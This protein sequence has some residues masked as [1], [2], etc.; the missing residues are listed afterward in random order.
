VK[1]LT[2][3]ALLWCGAAQAQNAKPA[4][5]PMRAFNPPATIE[6]TIAG[7]RTSLVPYG[8]TPTARVELVFR[9]GRGTELDGEA[10]L[11]QLVGDYLLEGTTARA[12]SAVA[13]ELARIGT[14][15]G[16]LTVSVGT[17]ETIVAAEVLAESAPRLVEIIGEVAL[18]PAFD[19]AALERLRGAVRRRNQ[20]ASAEAIAA[21]RVN[22]A[23]FP[24]YPAD[25]MPTDSGLARL[26]VEA[27]RRFHQ[28]EYVA[29]RA[30]LYV[31][32]VFDAAKVESAARS[33]LRAI[34]AGTP[35][36][37]FPAAS[38]R[39]AGGDSLPV[40]QIIDRPGA[41][42]TRIH[43]AYPVVDQTHPDHL[44]LN[45]LNS[46]MGSVQ[47][48]RIIANVR[49]RHGYSYN[50]STRL[51]RRPGATSWTIQGD[52]NRDVTGAA[53]REI[54]GEMRRAGT[55]PPSESELA[56]FQRFMAGGMIVEMATARG[57]LDY[58]RFLDL[59]GADRD[60][61]RTL[62]P[63]IHAVTPTDLLRVHSQYLRGDRAV[64]VLVGDAAAI[65]PQLA[66]WAQV[67]RQE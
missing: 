33:A 22:N 41:T 55:E 66:G 62:V 10:G 19:S 29:A 49:E 27:A 7:M 21:A 50:I 48:S 39:T 63:S 51:A 13:R 58:L 31:A 64:I 15:G 45:E 61:L 46:V 54:L 1:R 65:E 57:I 12:G 6:R 34:R 9:S 23:L 42:Q 60:Y 40:V 8:T 32:G 52:V 47:T 67:R 25:R 37:P 53:L 59:Y 26:G 3:L 5:V 20:L 14:V 43:I 56:E 44:A 24:D 11:A 35:A 2:W 38:H 16:G 28:R 30:H 18:S 17:H 36:P 4:A